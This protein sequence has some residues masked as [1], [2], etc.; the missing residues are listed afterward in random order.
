MIS[1]RYEELIALEEEER[2]KFRRVR[3]NFER[4]MN[5]LNKLIIEEMEK[6]KDQQ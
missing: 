4:R 2:Q 3:D 6:G 1:K 5:L